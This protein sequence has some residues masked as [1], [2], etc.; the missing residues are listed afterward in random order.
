MEDQTIRRSRR[1]QNLPPL[2]TLEPPPPPQ[3][4]RLD[5]DG[6]FEPVGISEVLGE[7]EM[8]ANHFDLDIVEIEDLQDDEFA[9]NFNTPLTD[10]NDTVI[11]QVRPFDSPLLGVPVG[12]IMSFVEEIPFLFTSSILVEGVLP[13]PVSAPRSSIPSTPLTPASWV[14]Q[15][16]VPIRLVGASSGMVTRIPSTSIV[17]SSFTHTAQSGLVGSSAFVQGFSWNGVHIPPSTP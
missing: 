12:R 8:I 9:R 7:P 5:T 3:R 4:Q 6:S 16:P 17:P 13:S 14:V 15:P 1:L 2:V 11:V 10:L